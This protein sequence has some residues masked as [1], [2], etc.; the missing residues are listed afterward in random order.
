MEAARGKIKHPGNGDS[1]RSQREIAQMQRFFLIV[2]LL[3]LAELWLLIETGKIIGSGP[4]VALVL[5]TGLLGALLIR[6][7]GLHLL[8]RIRADLGQGII[9]GKKLFDAFC[10]LLG[11]ILLITPGLITDLAGLLFLIPSTRPFL[12]AVLIRFLKRAIL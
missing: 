10:V 8:S 2:A 4:T 6:S 9:P 12:K 3:P 11:G 7:Q 1:A 5:G